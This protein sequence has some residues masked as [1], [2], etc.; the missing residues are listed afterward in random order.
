MNIG[1]TCEICGHNE[2]Y[3]L[4]YH[5]KEQHSLTTK[6]YKALYPKSRIMTGHSKRTIEYWIYKGFSLDQ[7]KQEV[8]S[9][10]KGNFY[11][12]IDSISQGNSD[13]KMELIS[14]K[15]KEASPICKEYWIKKGM[16]DKEAVE[17]VKIVQ[18]YRSSKSNKFKDKQHSKESIDKIRSTMKDHI[19]KY[20]PKKWI[21]HFENYKDLRSKLEVECYNTLCTLYS[22]IKASVPINNY[23]A[24][25]IIN[26][27]LIVE[28]FGDYWHANPEI[29]ES[30]DVLK[31]GKASDIW[32][33]DKIKIDTY[34][35]LGYKVLIIWEKDWIKDK[36]AQ[37]NKI[38][39]CI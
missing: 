32:N 23:I 18:A 37:L 19:S 27:N 33:K 31:I 24:D 35:Q 34:K 9:I 1:L 10:Q 36:E 5:L 30:E 25:L 13:L 3:N 28:I 22:N 4:Q 2:K 17:N 11:S 39:S 6:Q 15:Q 21:K 8:S 14:K 12:K 7:A 29:Y 16:S 26:D 38:N 20:G